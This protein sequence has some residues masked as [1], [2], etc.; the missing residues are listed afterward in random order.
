MVNADPTGL[1]NSS[2]DITTH[3]ML[4]NP[5]EG[6]KVSSR[7]SVGASISS[8][9]AGRGDT[10]VDLCWYL[11]DEFKQL[12]MEQKEECNVW[13]KSDKGQAYIKADKERKNQND[14]LTKRSVLK[15][16]GELI[17]MVSVMVVRVVNKSTK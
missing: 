5:V 15:K 3:L 1:G 11:N 7:S 2:E 14:L 10:G 4:A 13:Q 6:K 17:L 9:L 12:S 16:E 8:S